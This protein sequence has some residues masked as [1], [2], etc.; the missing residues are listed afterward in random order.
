MDINEDIGVG[1]IGGDDKEEEQYSDY[2]CAH[3]AV[4]SDSDTGTVTEQK[5]PMAWL[6]L[7]H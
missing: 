4:Y 3:E 2:S 7:N 1:A 6:S 5:K